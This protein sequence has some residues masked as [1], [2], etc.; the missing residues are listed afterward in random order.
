M[1][2]VGIRELKNRL[3]AYIRAVS[4]GET[5]LVTDRGQVVAEL[6]PPQ[7]NAGEA[8]LADLARRGLMTR[9]G[10]N[11]KPYPLLPRAMKGRKSSDLLDLE[12]GTF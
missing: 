4:S 12:R 6:A 9:A 3:S 8:G 11:A 1:K 5:V 2:R 10:T 7:R